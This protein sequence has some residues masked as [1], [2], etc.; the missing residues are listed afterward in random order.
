MVACFGKTGD[1]SKTV[2][3]YPRGQMVRMIQLLMT[4][5]GEHLQDADSIHGETLSDILTLHGHICCD[6]Y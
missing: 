1:D 2:P 4:K 6:E 3:G 5:L